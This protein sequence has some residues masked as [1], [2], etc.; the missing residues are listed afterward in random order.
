MTSASQWRYLAGKPSLRSMA[1]AAHSNK[2]VKIVAA[3]EC[4][5][6]RFKKRNFLSFNL[7]Q[8]YY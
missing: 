1:A 4:F 6:V 7:T 2:R 8:V 5:V 3:K